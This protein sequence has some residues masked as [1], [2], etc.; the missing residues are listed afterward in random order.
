MAPM[1]WTHG[2]TLLVAYRNL[3]CVESEGGG[4]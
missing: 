2:L 4:G 3:R 1:A